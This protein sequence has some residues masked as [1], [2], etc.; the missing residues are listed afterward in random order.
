MTQ[1][2]ALRSCLILDVDSNSDFGSLFKVA[3]IKQATEGQLGVLLDVLLVQNVHSALIV[4]PDLGQGSIVQP[5][6]VPAS[7]Q[8]SSVRSLQVSLLTL[9]CNQV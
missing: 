2:L 3:G 9:P 5:P 7:V 6:L 8:Y 1:Y 4:E